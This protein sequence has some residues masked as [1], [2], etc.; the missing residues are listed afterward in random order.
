M[1]ELDRVGRLTHVAEPGEHEVG[2][3]RLQRLRH[4]E[5]D[6]VGF[7]AVGHHQN[8]AVGRRV[9]HGGFVKVGAA[10]GIE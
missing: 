9:E 2:L 10:S 3:D 1:I 7:G 4:L 8:L 6:R 5:G